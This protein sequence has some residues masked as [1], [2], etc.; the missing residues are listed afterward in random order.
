MGLSDLTLA[1]GQVVVVRSTSNLSLVGVQKALNFGTIQLVN[2]LSDNFSIGDSVVLK[3]DLEK[4]S[5][6]M[7]ISGK[8]YYLINEKDISGKEPPAS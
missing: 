8:Y 6:F 2:G 4:E 5:P 3:I 7:V 1:A